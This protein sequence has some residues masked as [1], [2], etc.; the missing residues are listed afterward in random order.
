VLK[1]AGLNGPTSGEA[2][3]GI[4]NLRTP[5]FSP[6]NKAFLQAGTDN[7][8]GTIYTALVDVNVGSK[9]SFILGRT[10]SGY[11]GPTY[12]LNENQVS[13]GST[14]A[15][16]TG[17]PVQN[18]TNG[19]VQL[20]TDFSDTY[21]LNAELAKMRYTFSDATSLSF[22]FLGLQGRFDPQGGAYG[23]Y[24]GMGT[25]PLCLNGA[26]PGTAATCTVTS[27]YNS[28]AAQGLVGA[29]VPMYAF[30]PSS[31]VRQNQPNW[32]ADFKTT[33]KNDTILFRPYSAAINRLIDGTQENTVPGQGGGGWQ[34]VTNSANCQATFV[35]ASVANGGASG[36]CYAANTPPTAAYIGGS[37]LPQPATVYVTTSTPL[38]CT[39]TTP[40]F[41]TSTGIN[42]AGQVGY[43]QLFTTLELDHVSGYTFSY[44]HPVGANTYNVSFDHY[45]DDTTDFT[46]DASPLA[47]GCTFVLQTG[48]SNTNP[49]LPGYQATCPLTSLRA[50][51]IAVPETFASVSSLALTAQLALTP[52]FELDLGGY[53]TY[54]LINAQQESPAVLAALTPTYGPAGRTGA[55]PVVLSGVQNFAAH[56]DPHTG[57]VFRPTRDWAVRFTAGSSMS[58]PYASLVSGF[59]TYAQGST[60][61]TITTPN[62]ALRPEELVTLDLGSD[63][64]TPDGTVFS[65]DI[66]NIVVHNPWINPKVQICSSVATCA[67][68]LPG[69]EPTNGGYTSLTINGPQQYDQGIEFSVANEPAVGFGYRVNTAFERLYY[70]D[71]PAADLA[72]PQVYFNGDQFQS[73]GSGNT[74]VPY[75]K[76]YLEVQYAGPNK[77]LFRFGADYEGNNNEYN[78]PAFWIF[79][80][81]ARI[82]T[83]WHD[84]MLG[85]TVENLFGQTWGAQLARGVEYAGLE[86]VTAVAA[87]GG[88]TYGIGT[89]NTA[90]VSPGPTTVRITLTKQF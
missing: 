45:Y 89:Y 27:S 68:A 86:P 40:C 59:T 66:Y 26:V 83:G 19:L 58:I 44:I 87:P 65:G 48:Q 67:I 77:S 85:A 6:T 46:N 64:R 15:F 80:A 17:A 1:G 37:G 90:L 56:F 63:F 35:A 61:T 5:D 38:V 62:A 25:I 34:E 75:A 53:F 36:P 79:D 23:Q 49:A 21:S 33:F 42:N 54:Y 29:S 2:G 24:V 14:P 74:S 43:G 81:G 84:V 88:Y 31:D 57:F 39:V 8:G 28:P 16:G 50:S 51:P 4:V 7:Y 78:A 18:L 22:E 3:A 71:M 69:L 82:N 70:L 55:I 20:N 12:G 73:T 52:K 41:T 76:G 72:T 9:L 60:S 13:L 10:F 32:N 30:F 47:A 11:R